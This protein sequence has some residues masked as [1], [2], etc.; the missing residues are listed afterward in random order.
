MAVENAHAMIE[1]LT[2]NLV[3]SGG[4]KIVWPED[5]KHDEQKP[6]ET[7]GDKNAA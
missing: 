7:T 4:Y 1:G 6:A 3:K 5:M 2:Y